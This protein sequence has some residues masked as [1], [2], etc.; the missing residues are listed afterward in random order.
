MLDIGLKKFE[1]FS[2]PSEILGEKII[3]KQRTHEY[4]ED[5][6]HLIDSSRAFLR[7]YLFWVDDTR[8]VEDVRGVTDIFMR[9]F[10]NQDSFEFV[11][12][13]KQ[14]KKLVGAGG[15]HTVSYMHRF[16]EF[17]YYLDQ[18]AIGR[19]YVT[20]VVSL[21]ERELFQRGIHRLIITCDV[22]NTASAAVA[23]R[24]G[25][26]LEGKMLGARYAYGEFRDELLYAKLNPLHGKKS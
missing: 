8:S 7:P 11:F 2:L 22:E 19:G 3:I 21:L 4:D 10:T 12:L 15:V 26:A 6:W 9:N 14:S 17:G 20:E 13:D 5:L 23:E 24:C 1:K 16:A 18:A 25:F